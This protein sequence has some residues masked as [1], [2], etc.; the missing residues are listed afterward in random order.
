MAS[1]T[2][3]SAAQAALHPKRVMNSVESGMATTPPA[4]TPMVATASARPR[5]RTNHFETM[6]GPMICPPSAVIAPPQMTPK[7]R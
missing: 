4:D 7:R 2:T 3:P 1:I 5:F 6:V